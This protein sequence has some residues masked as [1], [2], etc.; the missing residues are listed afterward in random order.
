[1]LTLSQPESIA[2]SVTLPVGGVGLL[3]SEL[4]LIEALDRQHP[5]LWLE[6][7]RK[8]ELIDRIAQQIRPFA[9]AFHPRPVFYRSLDLRSHEF[10]TL[11]GQ[12]PER[13]PML[14]LRGTLSYQRTP[15]S[16]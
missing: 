12:S 9:E 2:R 15:A 10:S 1:M 4:L 16:V 13:Y 5:R 7:G 6:Q 3:R 14:G 8:H 11:A